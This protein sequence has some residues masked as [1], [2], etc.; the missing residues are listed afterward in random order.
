MNRHILRADGLAEAEFC[1]AQGV[2]RLRHLRQDWPCRVLFPAK[3]LMNSPVEAVIANTAGGIVG[4]D[5]IE[6]RFVAQHGARVIIT[7]Q[8]AE[9]VYRS[10]QEIS[11]L[12]TSVAVG[13]NCHVEWMPQETI[14]FEGAKLRRHNRISVAADSILLAGEITIFGR[15]ARDETFAHGYFHDSWEVRVDQKLVWSDRLHIE[16][17]INGALQRPW[18]FGKT[19]ATALM[20]CKT[21]DPQ[22]MR[23]FARDLLGDFPGGG[24]T[25]VAGLT[26]GRFVSDDAAELRDLIAR[27]W[28]GLRP[29]AGLSGADLPRVWNL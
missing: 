21:S 9:K 17:G 14:L 6:Q 5:R 24:F 25:M 2:T 15:R 23:E 28:L 8:A 12:V 1:G 11:H 20:V 29:Q 26:I 3:A 4:G 16:S 13:A 7:S 22:E 10:V 19:A 18:S 27:L